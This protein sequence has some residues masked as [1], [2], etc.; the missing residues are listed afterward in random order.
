[1]RFYRLLL[2]RKT[3]QIIH[4]KRCTMPVYGRSNHLGCSSSMRS[5]RVFTI[6]FCGQVLLNHNGYFEWFR[7]GLGVYAPIIYFRFKTKMASHKRDGATYV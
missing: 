3:L 7:L 2:H 6:N 4:R 5:C 1:M